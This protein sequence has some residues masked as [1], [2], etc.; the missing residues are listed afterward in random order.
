MSNQPNVLIIDN[1]L[2]RPNALFDD[3]L[4]LVSWDERMKSRK[5]AS[6]GIS[7]NY[8]GISYPPQ[9]MLPQL[10][11][12][13]D[14]IQQTVGFYP[15]NC[16]LN[17]YPDSTSTMG[18]HS[19]STEELHPH[20]GVVIVS[21]G[22]ERIISYKN[23]ANKQII[24]DFLLKNGSLLYMDQQIQHE[25]LHAIPQSSECTARMSL[26]FRCMHIPT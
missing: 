26:T 9:P 18:Y 4:S 1:F 17:Y 2:N 7:Y 22:A 3:L 11:T 21:L 24:L 14:L 19:D 15:N 20:T 25:W 16:L 12:L 10:T 8:S 6:F 5:T 23:K 13:C